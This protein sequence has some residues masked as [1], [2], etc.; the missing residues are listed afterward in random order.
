MPP[1]QPKIVAEFTRRFKQR[2]TTLDCRELLGC[3]IMTPEGKEIADEKNLF[4]TVCPN[5]VEDAAV[6][7]Q[8][9]IEIDD[10]KQ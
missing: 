7:V 6:I 3:N 5:F 2:H 10:H 8:E 4:K 1:T 9:L